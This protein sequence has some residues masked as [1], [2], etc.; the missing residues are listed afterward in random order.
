[1]EIVISHFNENLD[2]VRSVNKKF[3]VKIYSKALENA[4]NGSISLPNV[5]RE[6]HTFLHHI[7]SNWEILNETTIFLQGNPFPHFTKGDLESFS[8]LG[9]FGPILCDLKNHDP[10]W[11][12]NGFE[13]PLFKK[14]YEKC[15]CGEP[16]DEY[17]FAAGAQWFCRRGAIKSKSFFW[18]EKIYEKMLIDVPQFQ[19]N[20]FNAWTLERIWG[21]FF[22][23]KIKEKTSFFW[24]A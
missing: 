10:I 12:T 9:E 11:S 1:M 15:L 23:P 7:V 6:A 22:D 24:A 5:N 18:W 21:Y 3:S 4:P 17:I 13:R 14:L 20:E 16:P 2:W 8:A 19:D